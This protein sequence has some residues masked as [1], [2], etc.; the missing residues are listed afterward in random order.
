MADTGSSVAHNPASNMKVAS[1][2][3]P[4]AEM[5]AR[6]VNVAL[7]T[8]GSGASDNQNMFEALRFAALLSKVR[9]P[10]YPG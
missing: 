3:A 7:G 4:V 2:I 9:S 1:G 10:D 5:L 8:D 6:G